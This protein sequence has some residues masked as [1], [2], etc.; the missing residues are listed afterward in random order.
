[1]ADNLQY[2][3][4]DALKQLAKEHPN[5][6][7][8]NWFP[9]KVIAKHAGCSVSSVHKHMKTIIL[10]QGFYR[11]KMCGNIGYRFKDEY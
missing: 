4:M 1:M 8:I 2:K 10:F 3:I 7:F 11:K 6:F 9:A 5:D